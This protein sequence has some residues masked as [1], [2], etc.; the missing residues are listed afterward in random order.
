VS[1]RFCWS[2]TS[3]SVVSIGHGSHYYLQYEDPAYLWWP[4]LELPAASA[5][6][7]ERGVCTMCGT[8]SADYLPM[9]NLKYPTLSFED[10]IFYNVYFEAGNT[11]NVVEMGLITFNERLEDGTVV[12]A[13]DVIASYEEAKGQYMVRSNGISAKKLGDTLYFKVYAKLS[14]GSYV[15]S[16]IAGYHAVAYASTILNGSYGQEA[17]ALVVAMLNYGAA[18]QLQ[19]GYRTDCLMNAH[20]T[21]EQ[22][23]LVRDYDASM[24]DAVI[25]ADINKVGEFT[26][27][28]GYLEIRP[29][30]SFEGAFAINFYFTPTQNT[31]LCGMMYYWDA[32]TYA[33]VDELTSKNATGKMWMNYDGTA[34]IGEVRGLAAKDIDKTIYIAG[35]YIDDAGTYSSGVISYS[36]GRYCENV[37]N[38]GIALGEATAV[39]GHYAKAYFA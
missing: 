39:Y 3:G 6:S 15:Y 19:F 22:R 12:E 23:A 18:A 5:H 10:E 20:L 16:E 7:F 2:G 11:K 30:V 29:S 26:S 36:L 33:R 8:E 27:N 17:K 37:A 21:P 14:D 25:P 32:D 28:N 9:L 1:Y 31:S 13:V 4:V 38:Q 24:L 35:I 34:W